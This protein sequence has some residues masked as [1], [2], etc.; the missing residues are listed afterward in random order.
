MA[1]GKSAFNVKQGV[2]KNYK[3]DEIAG[4][5]NDLTGKGEATKNFDDAGIPINKTVAGTTAH[6]PITIFQY[7]LGLYD[8]FLQT[9][10]YSY[11]TKFMDI[12]D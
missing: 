6:F 10:D 9:Q 4:Y 11:L 7:A 5:Y 2:G 3:K 1:S 8:K 12:A